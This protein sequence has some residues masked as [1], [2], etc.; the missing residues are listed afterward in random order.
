[1]NLEFAI[2]A[3]ALTA[4]Y[5]G[6]KNIMDT[7][8]VINSKRDL[9]PDI[10]EGGERLDKTR[11]SHILRTD[12][13]PMIVGLSLFLA[14]YTSAFF[15]IGLAIQLNWIKDVHTQFAW[16]LHAAG[17]ASLYA[18][19]IVITKNLYSYR[20]MRSYIEKLPGNDKDW[21]LLPRKPD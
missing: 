14:V 6:M 20:I 1:M 5:A 9:I 11:K 16:F 17:L 18:L 2:L 7:V 4:I 10:D 21:N 12:I 8:Y 3:G 19:Y 15:L 13:F